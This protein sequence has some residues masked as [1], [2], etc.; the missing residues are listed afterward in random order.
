MTAT[1]KQVGGLAKKKNALLLRG[2]S[3]LYARVD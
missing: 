3:T 2:R 1:L